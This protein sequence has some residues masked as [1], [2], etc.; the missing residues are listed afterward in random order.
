MLYHL[1]MVMRPQR[2]GSAFLPSHGH[3]AC[4]PQQ[5]SSPEFFC[6]AC[7]P[8][9]DRQRT[10]TASGPR[11]GEPAGDPQHHRRQPSAKISLGAANLFARKFDTA[12]IS[13]RFAETILTINHALTKGLGHMEVPRAGKSRC[14]GLPCRRWPHGDQCIRPSICSILKEI[15]RKLVRFIGDIFSGRFRGCCSILF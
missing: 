3:P 10:G 11:R 15:K 9:A 12:R 13:S 8:P 1:F 7:C 5:S 2:P 14:G 6:G 4:D